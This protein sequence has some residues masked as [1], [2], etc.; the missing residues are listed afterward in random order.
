[1]NIQNPSTDKSRNKENPAPF[2]ITAVPQKEKN[3]ISCDKQKSGKG[4]S[5]YDV[6][7]NGM[8]FVIEVGKYDFIE[9]DGQIYR[10]GE[11][12]IEYPPISKDEFEKIKQK[13]NQKLSLKKQDS[14]NSSDNERI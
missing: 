7:I 2:Y 13:R 11:N 6:D 14:K 12:G 9:R 1:M 3:G 4:I 10:I 8:P 5:A